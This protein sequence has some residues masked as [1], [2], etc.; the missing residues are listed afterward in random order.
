MAA[1]AMLSSHV[2]WNDTF[3][4]L[5]CKR[6]RSRSISGRLDLLREDESPVSCLALGM[7]GRSGC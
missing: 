7:I 5:P 1:R 6:E 3:A 2:V 4:L